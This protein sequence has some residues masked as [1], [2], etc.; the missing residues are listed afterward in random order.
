MRLGTALATVLLIVAVGCSDGGTPS[1]SSSA[2]S[3]RPDKRTTETPRPT[4]TPGIEPCGFITYRGRVYQQDLHGS[5]TDAEVGRSLGPAKGTDCGAYSPRNVKTFA[6]RGDAEADVVIVVDNYSPVRYVVQPPDLCGHDDLKISLGRLGVWHGRSTRLVLIRNVSNARCTLSADI[7]L[8]VVGSK[9]RIPVT[10]LASQPP[11]PLLP[12][13]ALNVLIGS[14]S[15]TCTER[16]EFTTLLDVRVG[17]ITEA[18]LRRSQVQT[19]CGVPEVFDMFA[20]P[21]N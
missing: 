2:A 14:G 20:D 5:A 17:L 21:L 15:S 4:L 16:P 7:D 10:P 12:D 8:T 13:Q 9:R 3:D 11:T 1:G 18:Y 6:S 19:N